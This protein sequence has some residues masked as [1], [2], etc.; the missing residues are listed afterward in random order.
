MHHLTRYELSDGEGDDLG[1]TVDV[2]GHAAR[3]RSG[4]ATEIGAQTQLDLVRLDRVDVKVDGHLRGAGVAE[5]SSSGA[6][7]DRSASGLNTLSP[8]SSTIAGQALA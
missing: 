4:E 1:R 6:L 5:P 8:H 3:F 7:V 2:G